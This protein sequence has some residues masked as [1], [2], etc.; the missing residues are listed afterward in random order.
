MKK[1]IK[2]LIDLLESQKQKTVKSTDWRKLDYII[3]K[4][5]DG[6]TDVRIENVEIGF[7]FDKNGKFEGIYNWKE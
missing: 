1:R 4:M 7:S 2:Q 6:G 3:K 5:S